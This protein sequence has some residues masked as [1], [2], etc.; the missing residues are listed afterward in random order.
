MASSFLTKWSLSSPCTLY[1]SLTP[2]RPQS[3]VL[4]CHPHPPSPNPQPLLPPSGLLLICHSA[5]ISYNLPRP[6]FPHPHRPTSNPPTHHPSPLLLARSRLK[7]LTPM[8]NTN[9]P[10]PGYLHPLHPSRPKPDLVLL[11][12]I[13]DRYPWSLLSI[14]PRPSCCIPT[15]QQHRP[16]PGLLCRRGARHLPHHNTVRAD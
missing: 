8:S 5:L 15:P 9:H 1:P 7:T 16:D 14:L 13:S 10:I 11:P 4:S 6:S 3:T 2:N 12:T